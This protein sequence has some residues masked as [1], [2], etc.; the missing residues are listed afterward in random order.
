[1]NFKHWIGVAAVAFVVVAIGN[2]VAVLR[3][4]LGS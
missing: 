1:M 3:K 2:R 4:G